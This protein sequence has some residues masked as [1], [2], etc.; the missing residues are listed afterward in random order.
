MR[1][2]EA[3]DGHGR[4]AGYPGDDLAGAPIDAIL[5]VNGNRAEILNHELK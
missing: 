3:L 1:P 2:D 5:T 4:H